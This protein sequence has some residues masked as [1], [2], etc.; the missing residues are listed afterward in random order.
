VANSLRADALLSVHHDSV[1]EFLI[2]K[3]E[4]EGAEGRYSD[5]FKGHSLFVS[6]ESAHYGRSLA[7]ARALGFA[8][9]SRG[10]EYAAHYTQPIMG[11]RRRVLVDKEAG[12][13]RFDQLVMLKDT[14]APAA[15]LEA[16]SI[17]N[18][19]EELV[20][21]SPEREALVAAAVAE[22]VESFCAGR[23]QARP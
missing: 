23:R 6:G 5:R 8:L 20:V 2:E 14:N 16:G 15:L 9:K 17:V 21:Q 3:W 10:L 11:S 13:Y 19:E 7:F 18:R 1:P 12:V 4:Y 22:A